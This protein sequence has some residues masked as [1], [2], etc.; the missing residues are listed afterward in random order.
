[1]D[2]H[3]WRHHADPDGIERD[4]AHDEAGRRLHLSPGLRGTGILDG[5]GPA[6]PKYLVVHWDY[7]RCIVL[8]RRRV[9]L[10]TDALTRRAWAHVQR[11]GAGDLDPHA[12]VAVLVVTVS[13]PCRQCVDDQQA[14]AGGRLDTRI[15]AK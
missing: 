14:A 2:V 8:R 1:M 10:V 12:G 13:P 5:L 15:G 9:L 6:V 11:S 4:A 3:Y 7:P